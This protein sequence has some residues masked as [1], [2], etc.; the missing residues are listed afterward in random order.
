MRSCKKNKN[1]FLL[2]Q[3]NLNQLIRIIDNK[4]MIRE[5]SKLIVYWNIFIIHI[6]IYDCF[7][8][9]FIIGFKPKYSETDSI[10][11]NDYLIMILYLFDIIIKL[12][13]SY[14][15]TNTGEET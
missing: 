2:N 5:R 3:V 10:E 1:P 6:A 13:T 11:I 4:W 12:R 15:N 8:I 7:H 9:P 14:F